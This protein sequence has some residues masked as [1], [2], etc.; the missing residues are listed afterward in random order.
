MRFWLFAF[1]VLAF[2]FT[3]EAQQVDNGAPLV[4]LP[5]T[6]Y[7]QTVLPTADGGVYVAWTDDR[8]GAWDIYA[9][10]FSPTGAADW[11]PASGIPVSIARA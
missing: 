10:K 3:V 6:Q 9:Q 11:A 1:A 2:P 5:G 4:Q 8:S 7:Q